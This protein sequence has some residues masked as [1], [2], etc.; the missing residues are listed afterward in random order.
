MPKAPPPK[1]VRSMSS[2][3]AELAG[4]EGAWCLIKAGLTGAE[5]LM[6]VV[7]TNMLQRS[8]SDLLPSE[9]AAVL[10]LRYEVIHIEHRTCRNRGTV[11]LPG[12]AEQ[13]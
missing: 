9:K 7:E 2:L 5:A 13:K 12:A 4:Q 1:G 3:A 8:F 11:R 6:Y 10:A